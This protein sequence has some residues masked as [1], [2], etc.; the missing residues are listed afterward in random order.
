MTTTV[1]QVAEDDDD[2]EDEAITRTPFTFH[3]LQKAN[4]KQE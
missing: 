1:L 4:W 3:P 2:D